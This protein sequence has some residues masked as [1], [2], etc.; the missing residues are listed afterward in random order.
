MQ[1]DAGMSRVNS[2]NTH[3][4]FSMS[5][6]NSPNTHIDVSMSRVNSPNTHI[7]VSMSRV[8]THTS[9]SACLG[10][11]VRMPQ[12][13]PDVASTECPDRGIAQRGFYSEKG[14]AQ[15]PI[16]P[17]SSPCGPGSRRGYV[18]TGHLVAHT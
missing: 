2:P 13:V 15:I 1:C 17:S 3:I 7:D 9:T 6:V 10:L 14:G 18:S 8:P 16:G 11:K 4:D 5:R 12:T